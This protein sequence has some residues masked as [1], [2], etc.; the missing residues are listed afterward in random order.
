MPQASPASS[1]GPPPPLTRSEIWL[2]RAALALKVI[3][4]IELGML[5]SVLPWTS[6]WSENSL[7]MG[8]PNIHQWLNTGFARG[9]VSG[10]GLVNIWIGIWDA[11]HYKED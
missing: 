5:L 10:L 1:P 3:F 6:V 7:T 2:R 4:F 8:W 9:A 11:V